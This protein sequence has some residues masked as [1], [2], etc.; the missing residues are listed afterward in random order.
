MLQ[1]KWME[2]FPSIVARAKTVQVIASGV[3]S[4]SGSLHLVH[5]I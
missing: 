2:L 4:A 1:N 5:S 3:S